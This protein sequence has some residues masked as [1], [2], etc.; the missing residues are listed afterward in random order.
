MQ[1]PQ[2]PSLGQEDLL[3]KGMATQSSTL[4]WRI[5]WTK[6]SGGLLGH[7]ELD[8]TEPLTERDTHTHTHTQ[9][10]SIKFI[11]VVVQRFPYPSPECCNLPQVNSVPIHP[12]PTSDNHPSTFCLCEFVYLEMAT[13][14]SILAWEIPWAEKFGGLQSLGLPKSLTQVSD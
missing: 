12:P 1:E 9:F 11:H 10:Y 5:P 13:H 14:S 6:E 4:P 3:E 7:K 8:T 2:V